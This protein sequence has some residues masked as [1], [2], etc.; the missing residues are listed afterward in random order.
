M[1]RPRS[2][3]VDNVF[4]SFKSCGKGKKASL[5]AV[6]FDPLG[7]PLKLLSRE[8]F[9]RAYGLEGHAMED[10]DALQAEATAASGC[11][12]HAFRSLIFGYSYHS[13]L[14]TLRLQIQDYPTRKEAKEML[15]LVKAADINA[16]EQARTI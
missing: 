10:Y 7:G 9:C 5:P 13:E 11:S 14:E 3:S 1:A 6:K 12:N 4:S 16:A 15:A 2:D 8:Y